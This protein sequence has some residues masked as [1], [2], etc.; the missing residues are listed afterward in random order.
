MYNSPSVAQLPNALPL[1]SEDRNHISELPQNSRPQR[2]IEDS[3]TLSFA[4]YN[5][6]GDSYEQQ[7]TLLK[8]FGY[9]EDSD[10]NTMALLKM[11]SGTV[12][13]HEFMV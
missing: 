7:S 8:S 3:N 1:V 12:T 4:P 13:L 10:S 9:S 6:E 5:S 11:V 2:G